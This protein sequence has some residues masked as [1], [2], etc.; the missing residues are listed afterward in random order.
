MPS[1]FIEGASVIDG[2]ADEIAEGHSIWIV[3]G[4]V[5]GVGRRE[6]FAL[7]PD[8]EIL[9]ARGRYVIPG[10]MNANVHLLMDVRLENLAR[11][12]GRYEE[13]IA[14][15]AQVALKNGLT[16]VFDTYGPRRHLMAVR[17]RIAGGETSGS[18]IF[19][20][21]NIVGFDGPFSH[22]FFAK[23]GEVASGAF[24]RRINATWV[25][26]I[27][28]H[29]MWLAP[30][31]VA[32]EV[33]AYIRRGI[34]FVKYGSNEH[35]GTS[36]GAFIAFS[37][38]V[39]AAIVEEAH[40][41][42][43]TAQAHTQSIEGLRLAV[44]AGCDLIQHANITGPVAI[45]QTTLDLMGRRKTGSVVFPLTEQRLRSIAEHA[46]ELQRTMWRASDTNTRNLIRSGA[47]LLLANDGSLFAPEVATDPWIGKSW[48]APSEE[49]LS[50]LA[51]GHFA[52]FKAME[53]KGCPPM[54]MLKAATRNIAAAYG[55]DRDL[56]T[57][58]PGKIADLLIL[59]KNPLEAAA[60]YRSIHTILKEGVVIDRDALPVNPIL[61]RPLEPP[62]EEEGSYISFFS[63]T[64]GGFPMCPC[65]ARY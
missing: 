48:M 37:P 30:E 9:D 58:E 29:L 33:R 31:Q 36:A 65:C 57:I 44:E 25:E 8:T 38:Q 16:T 19:C 15:A 2:I 60:N 52:W 13:L 32:A 5:R 34:D 63:D 40:R 27:G 1:L 64:T 51:T 4:R 18:R 53:E 50:D 62:T 35:F 56:G 55:K 17:E 54:Q 41:A 24:A 3:D 20:A 59:E 12:A 47:P 22:D 42:G 6:D 28:R 10:L 21:G 45:P 39:Q 49:N 14:E 23:A 46:S 26:N 43:I 11:Y 7:P 61:T